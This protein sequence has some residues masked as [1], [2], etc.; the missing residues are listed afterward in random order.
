MAN[1]SATMGVIDAR[2]DLSRISDDVYLPNGSTIRGRFL[3]GE[4]TVGLDVGTLNDPV[5]VVA[6]VFHCA[7]TS[8]VLAL[9]EGDVITHAGVSYRVLRK[10]P[11]GGDDTGRVMLELGT[12]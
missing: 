10:S 2:L 4:Q 7:A 11:P 6:V 12:T 1:F 5:R 9:V 3:R 8:A